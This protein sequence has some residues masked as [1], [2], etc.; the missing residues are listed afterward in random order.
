[1]PYKKDP[2]KAKAYH[3]EYNANVSPEKQK[4]HNRNYYLKNK[5]AI[6]KK[7]KEYKAKDPER[8]SKY[9]LDYQRK[10]D[11]RN[12][13]ENPKILM[14]KRVKAR[15]SITKHECTITIDDFEIPEY[16]PILGLRL[17][18]NIGRPKPNSPSVD[19]IDNT[20][21]Y[22]PG[23]VSVISYRANLRKSDMSK[24]DIRRMWEYVS[25]A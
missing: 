8:W 12:R 13:I 7:T 4:V 22:I 19:R 10:T 5:E 11:N 2:E 24:E 18:M 6:L 20:K 9:A 1:M 3:K 25:K 16:C 14:L 23:N 17:E 21:G 15:C